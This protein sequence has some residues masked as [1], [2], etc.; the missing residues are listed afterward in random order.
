MKQK[1]QKFTSRSI[2]ETLLIAKAFA[3]ELKPGDIIGLN[4]D[5]GSGKT[6][7]IKGIAMGLGLRDPDEVKSPTFALM[8]IYSTLIVI[9]HF[10]LYRLESEKEIQDM[11]FEEYISN[12]SVI[13]CIEW[14]DRA[15]NLLPRK[16]IRI[17]CEVTG[18][19][20]RKFQIE[21]P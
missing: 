14:A 20:S 5:L 6:A 3:K 19:N 15:K 13:S 9:Y 11:G 18:E 2:Q 12:P 21:H 7:F 4:G 16:A 17:S 8:H 10:D 1:K